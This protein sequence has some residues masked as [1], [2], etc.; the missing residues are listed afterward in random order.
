LAE[1]LEV[2]PSPMLIV[3]LLVKAFWSISPA[4]TLIV[5]SRSWTG[6]N[7]V[8]DLFVSFMMTL[9]LVLTIIVVMIVVMTGTVT[10]MI[11]M[12]DTV[13][14]VPGHLAVVNM[15]NVVPGLHPLKGNLMIEGLQGMTMIEDATIEDATKKKIVTMTGQPDPR[16]ARDGVEVVLRL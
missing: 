5:Q 4:M 14:T 2:Y 12:K 3:T 10:E 16:M 6:R 7:S 1:M 9:V 11:V 15:K 13:V 8:A